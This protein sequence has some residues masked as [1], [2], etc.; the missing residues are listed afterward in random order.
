MQPF[1][2]FPFEGG[3]WAVDDGEP[4]LFG[5]VA[6]EEKLGA[7]EEEEGGVGLPFPLNTR[8]AGAA[9]IVIR[10]AKNVTCVCC[11]FNT[12]Y[13]LDGVPQ[14]RSRTQREPPQE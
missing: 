3:S 2:P 5:F 4:C 9:D 8:G 6:I 13:R 14:C 7:R 1:V 12:V 10:N 11:F